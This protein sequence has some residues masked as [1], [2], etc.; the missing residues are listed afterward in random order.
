[1]FQ[2]PHHENPLQKQRI[3][4]KVPHS[5]KN[6]DNTSVSPSETTCPGSKSPDK[7]LNLERIH[8]QNIGKPKTALGPPVLESFRVE[9]IEGSSDPGEYNVQEL[10]AGEAESQGDMSVGC[11]VSHSSNTSRGSLITS[12]VKDCDF[13][14]LVQEEKIALMKARL[15]ENEA[16][17]NSL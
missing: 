4:C 5:K 14:E 15:R 12:L 11:A 13:D 16:A 2:V 17:L 1:M 6:K 10:S 8:Y 7:K 3:S 9:P